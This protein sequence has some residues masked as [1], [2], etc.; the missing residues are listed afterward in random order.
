MTARPEDLSPRAVAPAGAAGAATRRLTRIIVTLT[1]LYGLW[2][3]ALSF[4]IV[5]EQ[6]AVRQHLNLAL[7]ARPPGPFASL[8]QARQAARD[9]VARLDQAIPRN[10][11]A[12]GPAFAL[13]Q[14]AGTPRRDCL[15]V[16]VPG[17]QRLRVRAYDTQGHRMDN[18]FERLNPPP[19][20]L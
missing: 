9:V 16:I 3:A 13:A 6:Q 10:P 7:R 19:R 4:R 15:V 17:R 20:R 1:V 12:H 8:R 5:V 2:A 18:I 11:C 14:S